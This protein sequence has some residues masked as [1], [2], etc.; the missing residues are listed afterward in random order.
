MI[1]LADVRA[2]VAAELTKLH[3]TRRD[4]LKRLE[5]VTVRS[6]DCRLQRLESLANKPTDL[7]WF[8]VNEKDVW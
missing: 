1:T 4:A 5:L 8:L 6:I 3:E 2:K 7:V